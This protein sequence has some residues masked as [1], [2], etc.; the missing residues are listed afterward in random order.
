M[1]K[2]ALIR[3]ESYDI[4]QVRAAVRRGV[5][6]VGGASK[7]AKKGTKLLL[8][9]NLLI[10]EVPEKCVT[11]HPSVF[12]AAAELFLATGASVSYGDSPSFGSMAA[13]AKKSGLSPVAAEL[14]VAEADFSTPEEVFFERGA[15]NKKFTLAKAVREHDV[16][17]SLPKLKTHGLEK[18]TGCVK[19]QFGCVPGMRKGEY[20]IKLRSA[21]DFARMLVD[22][23]RL[24]SPALYV[25]D[26]VVAMEGNGP[27]GGKPRAMNVILVSTDPVAL[28]ATVC[29][30]IGIDPHLV[31]TVVFGE[32]SGMGKSR[33]EDITLVGDDFAGFVNADFDIDERPVRAFRGRGALRFLSNRLVPRPRIIED[34]CVACGQCVSLCPTDPKSVNWD[35][36]DKTRP[37]VHDYRTCIR[38]YC[39]QEICPEGAIELRKPLVRRVFGG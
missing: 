39:C 22:L 23:N 32:E 28:D 35:G 20:H 8:K 12:R 15:Q 26:G 18:Y 4:N 21:Y 24:V 6:L 25:M 1:S 30:M 2:V 33:E 38:C 19:N 5:D 14:G 17:V 16:I 31:P 11:T 10:G 36:G 37:P 3:C 34:R 9:P 7:F 29:R 13:A 27:R